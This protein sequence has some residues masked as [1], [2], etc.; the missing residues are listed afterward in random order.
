MRTG[1]HS[2]IPYSFLS[3]AQSDLIVLMIEYV[4]VFVCIR[5]GEGVHSRN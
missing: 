4:S 3:G 2:P 1:T 5:V